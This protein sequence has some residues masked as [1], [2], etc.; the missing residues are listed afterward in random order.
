MNKA[1]VVD[2]DGTIANNE[3]RLLRSIK[4]VLGHD[5]SLIKKSYDIIDQVSPDQR[6]KSRIYDVFLSPK[7]VMMDEPIPGSKEVLIFFKRKLNLEVIYITGRPESMRKATLKWLRLYGYPVDALFM[8]KNK[9]EKEIIFKKRTISELRSEKEIV[10]VIGDTPNDVKAAKEN[11]LIAIA[12]LTNFSKNE[13][14]D[15]D[16]IVNSWED[17]KVIVNELT[18]AKGD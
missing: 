4:D 10:A 2:I 12:I 17:I 13:L 7:Y 15:A 5:I 11:D 3:K 18:K 6:T 16:Y 9:F 8:K 14:D 1:I